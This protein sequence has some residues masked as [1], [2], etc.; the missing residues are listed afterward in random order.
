V[1]WLVLLAATGC[2]KNA[3]YPCNQEADCL[4]GAEQG[5]CESTG[6]CSFADLSC[7]PDGRRYGDLSGTFAGECV[8]GETPVDGGVDTSSD[9]AIDMPAAP[10]CDATNEP[11]LVGCWEFEDVLTDASG[12][13]N[14][15]TIAA[16]TVTFVTGMVGKGLQ[17]DA[18]SH[19]A[20]AD[21]ASLAPTSL[22]IE[23]WIMPTMVSTARM[24]ILDNN[25][26]YGFFINANS[27]GL[28]CTTV[29]VA[30]AIPI[31]TFTHVAC[32][33][34]EVAGSHLYINGT[35][36]ATGVTG[37]PLGVGDTSGSVIGGNSPGAP[38]DTLVGVIDQLRVWNVARTAQQICTAAGKTT[39]P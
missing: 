16:G 39:C 38:N 28:Q 31:N 1:R 14:N 5:V 3:A 22:T 29:S 34:D 30:T 36:V 37:A 9:M 32:T 27:A 11:T 17:Q 21:T 24:G 13:N 12:D 20:V 7:G 8:A 26:S 15:G 19:V 25:N 33:Y 6:F 18:N 4:R 35:D 10:F 23:A 2:L